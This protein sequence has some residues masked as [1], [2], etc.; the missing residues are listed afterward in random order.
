MHENPS[1]HSKRVIILRRVLIGAAIAAALALVGLSSLERFVGQS[2]LLEAIRASGPAVDNPDYQGRTT[3]GRAYQLTGASAFTDDN[4]DTIL[5]LPLLQLAAMAD[6]PA[7][8]IKAGEAHLRQGD[9]ALMHGD[10][11]MDM[12]DGN[13]L[14]TEKLIAQ[15]D[16]Q[17]V[18]VPQP[19]VISGPQINL[20]AD[21]LDGNLDSQ[22]YVLENVSLTLHPT[23]ANKSLKRQGQ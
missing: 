9:E 13:R 3:S 2:T 7:I 21:S 22:I 20:T 14:N 16:D 12:S 18:L 17:T 11:R 1:H 10:V 4:E 23:T 5:R 19:L 15:L 8:T 6:A